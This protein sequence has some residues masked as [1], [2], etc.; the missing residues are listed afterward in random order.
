L[1]WRDAT[2]LG[3][4]AGINH[5]D[6]VA[7]SFAAQDRAELAERLAKQKLAEAKA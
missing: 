1:A 5:V 2:P 7:A 6:R 4:V 3:P